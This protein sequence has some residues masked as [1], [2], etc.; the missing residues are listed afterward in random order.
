VAVTSLG[1]AYSS[2]QL[3]RQHAVQQQQL[4]V[5]VV[6]AQEQ[7]DHLQSLI[8]RR[9]QSLQRLSLL[10]ADNQNLPA[11]FVSHLG[12][13]IPADVT[14]RHTAVRLTDSE[15]QLDLQ[16]ELAMPLAE[17]A[18]VLEQLQQRLQQPPWNITVAQGWQQDWYRQLQS[19]GAGGGATDFALR[20]WM[21]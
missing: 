8:S 4:Q 19:G 11:L 15:W 9:D 14:L 2:E 13:L 10:Q 7:L 1:L 3:R 6:E 20:G 16:G 12:D 18:P 5:A 17:A 21:R